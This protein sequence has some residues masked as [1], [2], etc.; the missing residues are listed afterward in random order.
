MRFA[1]LAEDYLGE[2]RARAG[3][4]P[5]PNICCGRCEV[6][7]RFR[8]EEKDLGTPNTQHLALTL[9]STRIV[10]AQPSRKNAGSRAKDRER[11]ERQTIRET[12]KER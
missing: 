2:T 7:Q 11:K 6:E 10:C 3:A 9:I 1:G 12:D 5:L 8:F 4:G